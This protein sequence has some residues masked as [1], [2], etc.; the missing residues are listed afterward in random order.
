LV[1]VAISG[2]DLG[3]ANGPAFPEAVGVGSGDEGR[4]VGWGK[5]ADRVL[6]G[7]CIVAERK[8]P[9]NTIELSAR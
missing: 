7:E 2:G 8:A 4:A 9:A 3:V 5:E 6:G 1:A